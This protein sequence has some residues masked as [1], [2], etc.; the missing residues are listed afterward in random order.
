VV[1]AALG[2][3]DRIDEIIEGAFHRKAIHPPIAPEVGCH[4]VPGSGPLIGDSREAPRGTAEG[5]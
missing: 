4:F 3:R 2:Y 5:H 1:T